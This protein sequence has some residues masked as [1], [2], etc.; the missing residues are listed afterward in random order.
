MQGLER[1]PRSRVGIID[2]IDVG[3]CWQWTG[4]IDRDGY[5]HF[6]KKGKIAHRLVWEILV[7][8]IPLGLHLDHLCRNKACVNP[9]HLEPVTPAENIRRT[10]PGMKGK[11]GKQVKG[12]AHPN[13]QKTHCKYGHEFTAEN[14]MLVPGWN[15]AGAR[16]CRICSNRASNESHRQGKGRR[17]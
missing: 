12:S 8:P 5:G 6:G 4:T 7:G 15:G 13:A 17:R 2:R 10:P 1:Q 16:R 9:D 11:H 14:T 3:D